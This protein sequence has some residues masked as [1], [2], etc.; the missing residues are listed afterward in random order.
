MIARDLK[1]ILQGIIYLC[2]AKNL[3]DVNGIQMLCGKF[4][5]KLTFKKERK[6]E[7][8]K[9]KNQ[10]CFICYRSLLYSDAL[11]VFV[12]REREDG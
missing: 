6:E 10:I 3:F 5:I 1:S 9:K 11:K 12:I 8:K 4:K 7:K 2:K